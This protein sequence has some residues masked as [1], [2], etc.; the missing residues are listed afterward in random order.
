MALGRPFFRLWW[1]CG[2]Y[3]VEPTPVIMNI[4]YVW[5]VARWRVDALVVGGF[6]TV[7]L[8]IM[9]GSIT[10]NRSIKSSNSMFGHNVFSLQ[11]GVQVHIFG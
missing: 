11:V 5:E 9:D 6:V 2:C 10:Y 8:F 7:E 1:D 3:K 4:S